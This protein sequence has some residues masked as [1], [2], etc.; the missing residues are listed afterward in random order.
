[1]A[2]MLQILF[3]TLCIP[4]LIL[5]HLSTLFIKYIFILPCST[6]LPHYFIKY[7]G[8]HLDVQ[9]CSTQGIA[10]GG[11]FIG[12]FERLSVSF[13]LVY[14]YINNNFILFT[15]TL[16]FIAILK[17]LLRLEDIISKDEDIANTNLIRK[18]TEWYILGTFMGIILAIIITS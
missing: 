2:K 16:Q 6:L 15:D 9:K 10:Q 13:M 7:M 5:I 17:G 11:A 1:M 4:L 12:V 18:C 14:S 8:A 3:L